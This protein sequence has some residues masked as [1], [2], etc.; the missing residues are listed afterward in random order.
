VACPVFGGFG[1]HGPNDPRPPG[2]PGQLTVEN[3]PSIIHGSGV[4][5]ALAMYNVTTNQIPGKSTGF[6]GHPHAEWESA[7]TRWL[8]PCGDITGFPGVERI[9][10]CRTRMCSA[11]AL[12]S[13]LKP[14]Q[15]VVDAC[16]DECRGDSKSQP[17]FYCVDVCADATGHPMG[18][19]GIDEVSPECA[20]CRLDC[21]AGCECTA[22]TSSLG[23][24]MGITKRQYCER[25]KMDAAVC[26]ERGGLW[27]NFNQNF[28][29]IGSAFVSLIEIAT[30]EGWVDVMYAAVDARDPMLD[31]VRD[32]MPGWS[33]FFVAFIFIGS[34]FILNLCVGVIVD[35]FGRMKEESGE[36]LL[37][38]P[39]QQQWIDARKAIGNQRAHFGLTNLQLL[40]A[41]RRGTFFFVTNSKFENFIMLCIVL[42][43]VVMAVKHFPEPGANTPYQMTLAALNYLFATVFLFEAILKIFALRRTYFLDNWNVFDF[44]CVLA[45]VLGIV[46]EFGFKLKVRTVMSTFRLFRIARLFR[47][48][49]F[50]KGLNQLFNAFLLSIPKLLNVALILMLLLF[51]FSVMGIHMFAKTRPIG[52]HGEHANFKQFFRAF[53]TLLRCMTGE[54][55][56]ELMHSMAK[57]PRYFG[58]FA[59]MP[60]IDELSVSPPWNPITHNVLGTGESFHI[61]KELGII[62]TPIMCGNA[63]MAYFFFIAYT[64]IITFVI[65]NLF[66]AVVLEG[67]EGTNE[68]DEQ[69]IV[70]K[71]IEVWKRYDINLTMMV[72]MLDAPEFIETVQAELPHLVP[73]SGRIPIKSALLVL[74]HMQVTADAKVWFKDAVDGA[75]RLIL[76]KGDNTLMTELKGVDGVDDVDDTEEAPQIVQEIAALRMQGA[77]R[78]RKMDRIEKQERVLAKGAKTGV[79]G[80][81]LE[82]GDKT[83]PLDQALLQAAQNLP[84]AFPEPMGMNKGDMPA[85]G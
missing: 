15:D 35:N 31:P 52:P 11:D 8:M 42:N 16:V 19:N 84:G 1:A 83:S 39:F 12:P 4:I 45:T 68:G 14:P 26:I 34:F 77:F 62:D 53:L 23:S 70:T 5:E 13:S 18:T 78:K 7:G 63:G 3:V 58:Q 40:P 72:P 60:C 10:G 69:A 37:L 67:F 29:N 79:G 6:V 76:S 59:M 57:S 27:V 75:L 51:L 36:E 17:S 43:S 65:L 32:T 74:G 25:Y 54:G 80:A 48:L 66:V 38:T 61:L 50:A 2:C 81:E 22:Y 33:L 82:G 44:T 55:W 20:A 24:I 9:D 73:R 46:L 21:Q 49:R 85:A 47:L 41:A 64:F 56:N 30:T 28:D 71:C